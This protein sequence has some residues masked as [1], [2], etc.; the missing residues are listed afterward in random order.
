MPDAPQ[1]ISIYMVSLLSFY[2]WE[3]GDAIIH[4]SPQVVSGKAKTRSSS[5]C[6]LNARALW[7]HW[8][9]EPAGFR[10]KR[11]NSGLSRAV[12]EPK[13]SSCLGTA[14]VIHSREGGHWWAVQMLS[15]SHHRT[16][17]TSL[18]RPLEAGH[19]FPSGK[20]CKDVEGESLMIILYKG[21]SSFWDSFSPL[22]ILPSEIGHQCGEDSRPPFSRIMLLSF[23]SLWE[24][25][26]VKVPYSFRRCGN[27]ITFGRIPTSLV[28]SKVFDM[29]AILL[30][31][32]SEFLCSS[33]SFPPPMTDRFP[34]LL[35]FIF[36]PWSVSEMP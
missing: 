9:A 12:R 7:Q 32:K 5:V 3:L 25:S 15:W 2:R 23:L 31:E 18:F 24:E 19:L 26:P 30:L 11:Q 13:P 8:S 28:L 33:V 36:C 22:K 34:V 29:P 17:C 4:T 20:N 21:A 6:F 1:S 10:W 27:K 16:V 14:C 35:D